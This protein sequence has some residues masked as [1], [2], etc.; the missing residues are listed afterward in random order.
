MCLKI[1]SVNLSQ[2]ATEHVVFREG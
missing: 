2:I 1:I